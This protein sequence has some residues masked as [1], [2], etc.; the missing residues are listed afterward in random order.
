VLGCLKWG[1]EALGQ[2]GRVLTLNRFTIDVGF[3]GF[4]LKIVQTAITF[5]KEL[6]LRHSKNGSCSKWGNEALSQDDRVLKDL[7]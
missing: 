3:Q 5:D 7:P 2:H 4:R 1:N 6:G